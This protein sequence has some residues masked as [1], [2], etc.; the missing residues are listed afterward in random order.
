MP[1]VSKQTR[2]LVTYVPADVAEEIARRA[3]LQGRTV[4]ALLARA[5]R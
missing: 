5:H 4:S 1:A 3:Q 2:R